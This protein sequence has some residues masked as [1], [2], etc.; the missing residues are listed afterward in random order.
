MA[1]FSAAALRER[2]KENL[3]RSAVTAVAAKEETE[4]LLSGA[5][6]GS[7]TLPIEQI[8]ADPEQPRKLF[9]PEKLEELKRSILALGG[10]EN[11]V[12]IYHRPG[13]GFVIRH[14][15]RRYRALQELLT[16]G[17]DRFRQVPVLM[18]PPP[19]ATPE[20]E[21]GLRI[22]QVVE[23]NARESLL[24]LETAEQYHLIAQAGRSEPMR[25][26]ELAAL[27]GTEE[28]VVQR[29]L[30]VV[31]GLDPEDRAL[32]REAYPDAPLRPLYTL[33]QWLHEH[34][35]TLDAAQRREAV[36]RFA[37]ARP[38]ERMVP[39]VLR[40]LTPRKK[41][42]RPARTRFSVGKTKS[43]GYQVKL[44]V[45]AD[46]LRDPAALRRAREELDR[47]Q[48]QL[49]EMERALEGGG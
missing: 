9:D 19:E 21:Q 48:A 10:L 2:A 1:R 45:P 47:A 16:E 17:H 3:N 38:T 32:L 36:R 49:E 40:E 12:Q 43:G 13:V 35:R 30:F 26:T 39:V 6:A 31:G 20:G 18:V 34:G 46:L 37:E 28:R 29:Y 41:V 24:P 8:H 23:N 33:V 5:R 14:G 25:A 7:A 22:A 4:Q 15:E 11:P 42:G 44:T 27:T